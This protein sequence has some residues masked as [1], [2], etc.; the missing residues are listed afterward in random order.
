MSWE[1]TSARQGVSNFLLREFG[2]DV[3][4][5]I[6]AAIDQ[7][8]AAEGLTYK[9]HEDPSRW[10]GDMYS[11]EFHPE[12]IE[13]SDGRV[14]VEVITAKTDGDSW[15]NDYYTFIEQGKSYEVIEEI[16]NGEGES[17]STVK[18]KTAPSYLRVKDGSYVQ[19][20]S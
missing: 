17:T 18:T 20:V 4:T 10:E 11:G 14:L 16:Y 5:L 13:M 3:S 6:Q 15:G 1:Q 19:V 2:I 8:L 9:V 12:I 7:S